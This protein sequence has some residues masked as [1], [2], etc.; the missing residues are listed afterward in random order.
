[1]TNDAAA[2]RLDLARGHGYVEGYAT[3]QPRRE[4]NPIYS[5]CR[6]VAEGKDGGRNRLPCRTHLQQGG[7]LRLD[8]APHD[9]DAR[10]GR[11]QVTPLQAITIHA[12]RERLP[13][14]EDAP[15]CR[16]QGGGFSHT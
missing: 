14:R 10:E 7:H 11:N 2:S 5:S 8:G 15:E 6:D 4:G 9:T 1:M 16:R 13:N 12:K 3:L